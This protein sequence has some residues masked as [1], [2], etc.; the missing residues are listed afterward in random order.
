MAVQQQAAPAERR[1]LQ[2]DQQSQ[3]TELNTAGTYF[4]AHLISGWQQRD[5]VELNPT[6]TL[7]GVRRGG[8]AAG[9]GTGD[10]T[11]PD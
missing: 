9:F 5:K 1:N 10:E 2:Y 11:T 7:D 3:H 6:N 8:C 4:W